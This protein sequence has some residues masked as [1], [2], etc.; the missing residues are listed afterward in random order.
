MNK[1]KIIK[2]TPTRKVFYSIKSGSSLQPSAPAMIPMDPAVGVLAALVVCR[3]NEL[4]GCG[5]GNRTHGVTAY[6]TGLSANTLPTIWWTIRESN[7]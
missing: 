2:K 1:F 3:L 6:E 5:G 7:P 4:S